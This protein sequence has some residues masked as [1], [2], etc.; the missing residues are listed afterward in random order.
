MLTLLNYKQ[1]SL[2][3]P[4]AKVN[5]LSCPHPSLS[6]SLS[7]SKDGPFGQI[8]SLQT[9]PCLLVP[10]GVRGGVGGGEGNF[11]ALEQGS[12]YYGWDQIQPPTVL[13]QP[14]SPEGFF[15]SLNG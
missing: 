6:L 14:V 3:E 9:V 2:A 11:D 1:T 4:L 12:T 8:S 5:F 13:I 10:L 7:G 15:T